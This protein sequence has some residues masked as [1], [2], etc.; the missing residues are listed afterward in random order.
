MT[1]YVCTVAVGVLLAL[2]SSG[3]AAAGL[4]LVGGTQSGTQTVGFGDQSIGE[5]K[6]DADVTQAQGNGNVNVSPAVSIFGDATT[7]N[8]QGND[9]VAVADVDQSNTATQ[10]QAAQQQQSFTQDGSSGACCGGSS[11]SGEQSVYGGDQSI[12]KQRNDADV[13][14]YQGNGNVN[15]SPAVSVFGDATTWNAQGNGNKAIAKVAQSN[16]ATQTQSARQQQDLS[17]Q[18]GCCGAPQGCKEQYGCKP[19]KSCC[20]GPSQTGEQKAYFGDQSI[21][22]QKNDA[23]VTQYQGNDNVNVSPAIAALHLKHDSCSKDSY[24]RCGGSYWPEGGNASTWNAQGNGNFAFAG[25]DQS[26]TATQSQSAAQSQSFVQGCCDT[27]TR[28]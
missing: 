5:Q 21:G 23:D 18:G 10:T 26:N 25:V 28:W 11:Q 13:E 17:Q 15:V 24:G 4:P 27:V 8:S 3:T 22:K 2:A 19:R 16:Q 6:N 7:W 14:Q 12:G 9:N 20:D 1:R